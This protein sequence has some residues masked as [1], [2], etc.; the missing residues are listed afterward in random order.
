M[1][2]CAGKEGEMKFRMLIAA[3]AATCAAV[4]IAD[5][6]RATSPIKVDGR[7]EEQAWKDA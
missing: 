1:A 2:H 3:A 5:A 6:V 7:L 4:A